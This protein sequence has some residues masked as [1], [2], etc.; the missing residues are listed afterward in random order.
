MELNLQ[1]VIEM[2][3]GAKF[4]CARVVPGPLRPKHVQHITSS[5]KRPTVEPEHL[6]F[7]QDVHPA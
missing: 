4:L 1:R 3:H 6:L 5:P 7:V 2:S